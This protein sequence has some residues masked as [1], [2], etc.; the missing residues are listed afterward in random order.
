M[1][2]LVK[3]CVDTYINFRSIIYRLYISVRVKAPGNGNENSSGIR[4]LLSEI[5]LFFLTW[6]NVNNN[7]H[8][9][10]EIAAWCMLVCYYWYDTCMV[11]FLYDLAVIVTLNYL[12]KL[13]QSLL[14]N[15]YLSWIVNQPAYHLVKLY[16]TTKTFALDLFVLSMIEIDTVTD[17]EDVKYFSP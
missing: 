5:K 8:T 6:R 9:I 2:E 7:L 15:C 11:N 12:R 10:Q 3:Y 13:H 1:E 17:P 14:C 16:I 4:H